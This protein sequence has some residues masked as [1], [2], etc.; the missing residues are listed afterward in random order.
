MAGDGWND[1]DLDSWFDS[2]EVTS[3]N[4]KDER[5]NKKGIE[6]TQSNKRKP[7]DSYIFRKMLADLSQ[8]DGGICTDPRIYIRLKL[9]QVLEQV[10][11]DQ[12]LAQLIIADCNQFTEEISKQLIIQLV[13][14][15]KEKA[16]LWHQKKRCL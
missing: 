10:M 5:D 16:Y 8:A 9:R 7:Q 13:I 15:V 11:I 12:P 6:E 2:D 1:A 14:C 3:K 4:K